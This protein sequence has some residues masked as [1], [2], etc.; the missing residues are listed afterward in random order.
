MFSFVG[1]LQEKYQLRR[2]QRILSV[3]LSNQGLFNFC[4][5]GLIYNWLSLIF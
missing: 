1:H 2:E 4:W 3:V 5:L